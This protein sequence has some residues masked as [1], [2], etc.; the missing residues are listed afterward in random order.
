MFCFQLFLLKHH[1]PHN[2]SAGEQILA[3]SEPIWSIFNN[4][5]VNCVLAQPFKHWAKINEIG[6]N[7]WC[8]IL[9]RTIE[10]QNVLP[11]D[12]LS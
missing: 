11:L 4:T 10:S 3:S 2:T 12:N 1:I 8:K 6:L 9:K 5:I 7:K